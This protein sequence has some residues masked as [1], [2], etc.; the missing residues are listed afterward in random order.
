[1]RDYAAANIYSYLKEAVYWDSESTLRK[2]I[3]AKWNAANDP[4]ITSTI[5]DNAVVPSMS[6]SKDNYTGTGHISLPTSDLAKDKG[7]NPLFAL[8][9]GEADLADFKNYWKNDP[10]YAGFALRTSY[11]D[12]D[13][14]FVNG[15][16]KKIDRQPDEDHGQGA[17]AYPVD[18][19]VYAN[20][21]VWVKL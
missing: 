3:Q 6:D 15:K 19:Y 11:G 12:N 7:V 4:D 18:L 13:G 8:S 2:Q 5:R 1:M 17:G 9:Y 10:S 14:Y 21:A 20:P 16:T